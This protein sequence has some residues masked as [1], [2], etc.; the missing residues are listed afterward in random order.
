MLAI[1]PPLLLLFVLGGFVL[2]GKFRSTQ[3]LKEWYRNQANEI[4]GMASDG[5]SDLS[6]ANDERTP[7]EEAKLDLLYKRILQ[8]GDEDQEARYFVAVNNFKQGKKEIARSMFATLAP[9]DRPGLDL[10][11]AWLAYD[12]YDRS[13]QGE[14]IPVE[15]LKHHLGHALENPR[16]KPPIELYVLYAKILESENNLSG[17]ARVLAKASERDPKLVLEPILFYVR[18]GMLR[19]AIAE[20]DALINRVQPIIANPKTEPEKLVQAYLDTARAYQ[21]TNRI[22][23]SIPIIERG[24]KIAPTSKELKRSLSDSY[25]AKFRASLAGG[26]DGKVQA[27]LELLNKS[28][29]ADPTNIAT[30]T[31]LEILT[32]LGIADSEEKRQRLIRSIALHGASV[33]IRMLLAESALHRG[34]V[35]SAINDYEVVLADMPDMTIALNNLAMIYAKHPKPQF[36]KAKATIQHAI[37]LTPEVAEFY[38]TQGDIQSLAG[39]V[40]AAIQ[41][42]LL[43]LERSPERIRTR[44]KLIALYAQQGNTEGVQQQNEIKARVEARIKE[45]QARME[46]QGA[47]ALKSD[48]PQAE[49]AKPAAEDKTP[50]KE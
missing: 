42:Y 18:K 27:S 39:D 5:S 15:M 22:D 23:E 26:A 25:R 17:A 28:I 19:Q 2:A 40:A 20:A 46:A 6:K 1:L 7:E 14:K 34:E 44:D 24:L 37:E 29:A 11:H 45:L 32:K 36:E 8:I 49:D 10:A 43:A 4:T 41:A 38:D 13:R 9:D 48:K 47:E 31:E 21:I 12:M 33:S 30:Q 3:S 50:E 35:D 16:T